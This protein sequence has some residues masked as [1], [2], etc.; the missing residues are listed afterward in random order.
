[1]AGVKR[2]FVLSG[3]LIALVAGCATARGSL[4]LTAA[5]LA[6]AAAACRAPDARLSTDHHVSIVLDGYTPDRRRQVGCL[7]ER[8]RNY[9]FDQIVT[10]RPPATGS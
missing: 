1:M 2:R 8:L 7:S 6:R 4:P 5:V 9:H 3:L 10:S